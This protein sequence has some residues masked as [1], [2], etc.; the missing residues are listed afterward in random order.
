MHTIRLREP[1]DVEPA[2]GGLKR[3]RRYFNKPTNLA[4]GEQVWIVVDAAVGF[5]ELTLNGS[6]P[7]H[8]QGQGT[9]ADGVT[10]AYDVTTL[11]NLRN[12]LVIITEDAP[13]AARGEVRLEIRAGDA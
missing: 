12:E 2:A 5:V 6:P 13:T 8:A 11:L 7:P 4:A 1:W 3:H 10:R 9:A